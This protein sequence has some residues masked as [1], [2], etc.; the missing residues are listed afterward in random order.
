MKEFRQR[1]DSGISREIAAV[2]HQFQV[3]HHYI[4]SHDS[5][6]YVRVVN[7]ETF[8]H[9]CIERIPVGADECHGFI[10]YCPALKLRQLK[11]VKCA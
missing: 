2:Y 5:W 11:R 8:C 10:Q 9:R 3:R 4:L 1:A 6:V 7:A